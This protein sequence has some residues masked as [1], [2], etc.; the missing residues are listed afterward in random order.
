M[1]LRQVTSNGA[2]S[3]PKK[4]REELNLKA[5]DKVAFIKLDTGQY[6]I[7]NPDNFKS[8]MMIDHKPGYSAERQ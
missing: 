2:V 6:I 3:I 5:G 7:E 1:D 4:I 8:I